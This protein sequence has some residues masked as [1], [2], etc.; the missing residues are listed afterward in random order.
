MSHTHGEWLDRIRGR[1]RKEKSMDEQTCETCKYNKRTWGMEPCD[2][3]TIGG[4]GNKWERGEEH[5]RTDDNS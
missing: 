3:C 2:S 1:K 4:D 5:E